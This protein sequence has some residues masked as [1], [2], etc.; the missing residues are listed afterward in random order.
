VPV[1]F[2]K[3]LFMKKLFFIAS[4]FVLLQSCKVNS[5]LSSFSGS[6]DHYSSNSPTKFKYLGTLALASSKNKTVQF[7]EMFKLAKDTYG[8]KVTLTNIRKQTIVPSFLGLKGGI[9]EQVM[10][11]VYEGQ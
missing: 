11:D 2:G 6:S 5:N 9:I 10:F 4:F 3:T 7:S 8:P 1:N